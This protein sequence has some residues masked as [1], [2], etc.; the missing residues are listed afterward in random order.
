MMM[1]GEKP[2]TRLLEDFRAQSGSV[3]FAAASFWEGVDVCKEKHCPA[4]S[5]TSFRSHLP[6][7][8]SPRLVWRDSRKRGSSR[9]I[10]FQVPKG[11]HRAQTGFGRLIRTRSDKGILCI[12][13][14]R[15]L[16]KSYGALF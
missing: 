2:R 15:I 14:K 13:D 9:F 12:L 11:D 4:S 8:P 3:L 16:T 1:Q 10:D 7:S 5:W 6:P